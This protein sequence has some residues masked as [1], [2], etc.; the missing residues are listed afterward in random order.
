MSVLWISAD[1][2]RKTIAEAADKTPF[3]TGGVLLGY[4]GPDWREVVVTAVV[5][6][7]PRAEHAQRRYVPDHEYQNRTVAK[8]YRASGRR[9]TYLGDWHSHPGGPLRLSRTDLSTLRA[10]A[11][12]PAARIE[13]PLMMV[14]GPG[15]PEWKVAAWRWHSQYWFRR[16]AIR[17]AS[18]WVF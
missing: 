10:I 11:E 9:T 12:H 14:L 18:I 4:E 17:I 8:I 13:R 5:G 1:V 7:G 3:E 16:R 6:P 2:L 15:E